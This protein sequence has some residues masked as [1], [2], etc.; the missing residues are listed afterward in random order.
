MDPNMFS[1]GNGAG[2]NE[3][4]GGAEKPAKNI[5]EMRHRIHAA[6][7]QVVLAMS[8]VPRYRHL[9]LGDLQTLVLEPLIRDR[10]AI[11]S[12]KKEEG[13][14]AAAGPLAGVAIWA[15]VSDDV[16]AKIREQIKAGVF[17]IKLKPEDWVSGDKA[18]LLDVIAPSQKLA[19]SVLANFRQLVKQGDVRIHPIVARMVDPA[20]LKKMGAV[21]EGAGAN[22]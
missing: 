10:I 12:A 11:A 14:D 4:Q 5:A 18:W 1:K 13:V 21:G 6:V 16:D 22:A 9:P 3:P 7:G 8:A 19:S 15:S 2:E 17:P 20:L